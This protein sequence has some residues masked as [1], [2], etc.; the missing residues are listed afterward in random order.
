[1]KIISDGKT[2]EVYE[3]LEEYDTVSSDSTNWHVKKWS[4]GTCDLYGLHTFRSV[5]INNA[6]GSIFT[7]ASGE[8]YFEYPF[9]LPKIYSLV[10]NIRNTVSGGAG[11]FFGYQTGDATL[12][13]PWIQ[14]WRTSSH[15][16]IGSII[17]SAHVYARW[18]E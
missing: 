3:I 12:I 7:S 18:K 5:P 14:F 16:S 11:I 4:N 9:K 17:V 13:T 1:M 6:S 2:I 10:F 15:N 8:Y